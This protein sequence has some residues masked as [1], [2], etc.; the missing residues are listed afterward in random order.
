MKLLSVSVILSLFMFNCS[1]D[2]SDSNIESRNITSVV[3]EYEE[4]FDS[5]LLSFE[6]SFGSEISGTKDEFLLVLAL[7][8]LVNDDSDIIISDE[9]SVKVY[10]KYG[11]GKKIF[12][13]LGQGPGEFGRRTMFHLSPTNYLLVL[14]ITHP[15]NTYYNLFA[16]D[17]SFIE[18]KRLVI[19][20]SLEKILEYKELEPENL[21]LYRKMYALNE[22]EK[23]YELR[24]A[25][26][27]GD[28]YT[29][30]SE[31]TLLL[32]HE[33]N[34]TFVQLFYGEYP[35]YFS[36]PGYTGF[37]PQ[38]GLFLWELLPDHRIVY[39]YTDDDVH[40]EETDLHYYTL[41]L[42]SLD[43]LEK[44]QIIRKFVP[45]TYPESWYDPDRYN[46]YE[47][48]KSVKNAL[49]KQWKDKKFYPSVEIILTDGMYIFAFLYKSHY[50][51]SSQDSPDEVYVDVFNLKEEKFVGSFTFP[52]YFNA[53]KNG[54]AYQRAEDQN[55][56]LEIRKYKINPM[57][58]GLPEDPD[59]RT[60]K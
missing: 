21:E 33:F 44:K 5:E 55:G 3:D 28:N 1:S 38:Y 34:D 42:I 58:Y 59:W 6:L 12:G 57:V 43:T 24:F 17:Y 2:S 48:N 26:T 18:K 50:N 41:N 29:F 49:A 53:I 8:M 46:R 7:D 9:N 15:A 27:S 19:S 39:V 13:R 30:V 31:Y 16:P 60:K 47:L 35:G 10:D 4:P 25:K 54:Y 23:V 40:N 52:T 45:V 20:Q 37:A 51:E 36:T 56:F 32:I 11:K 22:S 14:D